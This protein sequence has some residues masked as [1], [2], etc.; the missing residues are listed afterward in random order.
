MSNDEVPSLLDNLLKKAAIHVDWQRGEGG[1]IGVFECDLSP[2]ERLIIEKLINYTEN[3]NFFLKDKP[4]CYVP[5]GNGEKAHYLAGEDLRKQ[6]DKILQENERK[7]NVEKYEKLARE[8]GADS[9]MDWVV[10]R[11]PWRKN[12]D[13]G[14]FFVV[15]SDFSS[16]PLSTLNE[17]AKISEITHCLAMISALIDFDKKI[18]EAPS[19]IVGGNKVTLGDKFVAS[20]KLSAMIEKYKYRSHGVEVDLPSSKVSENPNLISFADARARRNG[21]QK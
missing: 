7:Q 13:T 19:I 18:I 8:D 11:I 17:E 15:V 3:Q 2:N 20:E 1:K 9:L 21:V 5:E 12:P 10:K 16:S 14:K 4:I 6:V